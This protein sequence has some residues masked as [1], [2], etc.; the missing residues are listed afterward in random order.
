MR[1]L[2][3]TAVAGS[4]LALV[5]TGCSEG[6]DPLEPEAGSE[7]GVEA[8][9]DPDV[10]AEVDPDVDPDVDVDAEAGAEDGP[11]TFTELTGQATQLSIDDRVLSALAGLG[12]ELSAAGGATSE[13]AGGTTTFTFPVTGGE[14]TVDATGTE[15]F[16]GMVQHDGGLQLS[17]MGQSVTIDGLVLDGTQEE[18]T[19]EVVG[20]RVPLLPLVTDPTITSDG[21]QATVTW[22]AATLDTSAMAPFAEQL[23][24]ELPDL[25]VNTLE[26]TLEGS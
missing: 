23:G 19:A 7:P 11:V 3:R 12:V 4:L 22:S 21:E 8:E 9:V 5:L 6:A 16:T 2:K 10:D 18:L 20:N 15:R 1:A 14:A 24:L 17:A 26:T 13:T 25:Q